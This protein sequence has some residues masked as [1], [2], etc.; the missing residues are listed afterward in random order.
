MGRGA[1]MRDIFTLLREKELQL[2]TIT[3]EVEALRVAA[4]LMAEG[5]PKT[6]QGAQG[7]A[8]PTQPQMIRTVLE[9]NGTPMHISKII[10]VIK[11]K[12][13]RKFKKLYITS[14]I[15]RAMRK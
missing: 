8:M 11:K 2:K 13:N 14:I 6:N 4:Q 10:E 3:R 5:E 9:E 15:H 12:Y 1:S 7:S